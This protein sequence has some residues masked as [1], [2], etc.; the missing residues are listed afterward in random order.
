M[1]LCGSLS[2]LWHWLSLELEWK[3][4]FSSPVASAEFSKFADILSAALSQHHLSGFEIVQLEFHHLNYLC[5]LWCFLRSTWLH[6][7]G[8]LALKSISHF[9]CI[10]IRDLIEVI[11]E[12]SSSFPCFR[13]FESEFWNKVF[14]IWATVSSWSCFCWLYR[15]SPSL[16]AKNIIN[17]ILVL[18]IWWCHV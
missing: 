15:A 4:T 18:T 13:Q 7:P 5:S 8:I 2:I 1:Q 14:M 12:W 16:A 11:P 3:L 10:I 6:I 9:H 17:L